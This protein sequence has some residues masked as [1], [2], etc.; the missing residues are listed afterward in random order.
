MVVNDTY[1]EKYLYQYH[2]RI[3]IMLK[4]RYT[5]KVVQNG[6]SLHITIPSYIV[7]YKDVKK[8]DLLEIVLRKAEEKENAVTQISSGNPSTTLNDFLL[9][10]DDQGV[11][12]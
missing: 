12:V 11:Q 6:N 4:E 3:F 8:G 1:I 2:V 5:A 9:N 10:D 7:K